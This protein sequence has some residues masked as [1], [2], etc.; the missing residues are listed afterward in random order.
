MPEY[1]QENATNKIPPSNEYDVEIARIQANEAIEIKNVDLKIAESNGKWNSCK[2]IGS[3]ICGVLSF[4]GI[5]IPAFLSWKGDLKINFPESLWWYI[6]LV[7]NAI[8]F[9]VLFIIYVAWKFERSGKKRAIEEK[10]K[11]QKIAESSDVY[12]SSSGLTIQGDT[13]KEGK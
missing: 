10:Q 7:I 2:V 12:R 9:I 3:V 1:K 6:S 8:L 5:V 13:P 4:L 11:Y